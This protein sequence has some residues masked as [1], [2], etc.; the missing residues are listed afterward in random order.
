MKKNY[1]IIGGLLLVGYLKSQTVS[2]FFND[3]GIKVD[4]ALTLDPEGNLYGSNF[5]GT[6][7]YKITPAGTATVF[8][9]GF[10]TPNGTAF[11]SQHQLY[12]C[13]LEGNKIYK[14]SATGDF[15]DSVSVHGPSGIVKSQHS[16]TMIFTQYKDHNVCKLAPD[17]SV[18]VMKS[19]A[20]LNG[21]VGLSYDKT[22]NLYVANFDDRKI[23][24]FDTDSVVN[25]VA[26][27][28][29]PANGWLGFI[30]YASGTL[31][32][33]GYNDH[34]IYRIYQNYVDSTALYAGSSIGNVDGAPDVAKFNSPNGIVA[35]LTGDSLF[36]SDFNT[37]RIRI[38][39]LISS[40]GVDAKVKKLNNVFIY[41]NPAQDRI[42]IGY[43]KPIEKYTI[44]DVTGKLLLTG[45]GKE[46]NLG[47]LTDGLYFI[48]LQAKEGVVNST[49]VKGQL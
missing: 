41:P 22:G 40:T 21:P 25:Y 34:R 15:L 47:G 49:F 19:G 32:G 39:S 17:G 23:F 11:N 43:D 30:T 42:T 4:D 35:S 26:T 3:P 18:H 27:M 28:P 20:P 10:N 16:D 14:L 33:T 45:E 29:G 44:H 36:V 7:V 37:G 9:G 46:I 8:A 31:W 5:M 2:T 12:V 13:D 38:I 6:N 48:H 24:R 1:L